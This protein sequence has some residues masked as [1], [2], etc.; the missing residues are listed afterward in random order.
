MKILSLLLITLA[1]NIDAL[2]V[3]VSYGV[4]RI[5]LPLTSLLIISLISMT[6]ISLSMLAGQLVGKAIPQTIAQHAGGAILVII[7]IRALYQYFTQNK[8]DSPGMPFPPDCQAGAGGDTDEPVFILKMRLLGLIIQIL[9]EPHR[10]DLDMS[11]AISGR[12][13]FLL[14]TSLALDSLAAGAAI[15]LLGFNIITTALSVSVGQLIS[16]YIGL[17][18]GRGLDHHLLGRQV[19]VLP[20]LILIF[21]GVIKIY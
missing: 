5:K 18:L 7:G 4:R 19:A 1:L 15:S 14:G 13:A 10:A 8:H 2:G 12:E 17:T 11:G 6:A 16:I 21:L 9:K 3:G 20:G